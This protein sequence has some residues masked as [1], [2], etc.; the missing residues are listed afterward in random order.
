[1]AQRG[2][3]LVAE[4]EGLARRT[5]VELLHTVM[6]AERVLLRDNSKKTQKVRPMAS[7]YTSSSTKG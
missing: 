2:T 4:D 7:L 3:I 1:M 5:L 6:Q